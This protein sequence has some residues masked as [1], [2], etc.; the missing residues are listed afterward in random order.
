MGKKLKAKIHVR[1][2]IVDFLKRTAKFLAGS[3]AADENQIRF[4]LEKLEAKWDEFEEAQADIEE[5]DDHEEN[6]EAHREVR[7]NFEEMYFEVRAGLVGKLPH[8]TQTH[9]TQGPSLSVSQSE[10]TNVH[11]YVRLPQINLPEFDGSFDKWLPF[12]DTFKALIDSS[13]DLSGIQKFHYLRASLRGDALKL[14]DSYPMSEANYD[15]AWNGLVA[16]FSNGYLLKKRHLN[17]MFEFPKIRKESAIGIHDVIDC[18][19]RNTKILDQLGERTSSW[20]AM[21]THLMVSKLDDVTQKRWEEHAS[22]EA[23]PSFAVLLEFLKKQTRVLDAVLVDQKVSTAQGQPTLGGIKS[24][25]PKISVNSATER[26]VQNCV[27][28]GEQH[29]IVQCPSFNQLPVDKRLQLS[30]SKRLCS[31]C[32]GWNHLARDCPSKYRCRTCGK[33]HHSL[34]HPG[35]PG[36][37][38]TSTF[39][40]EASTVQGVHIAG[41]T[42]SDDISGSGGTVTSSLA[43]IATNMAIEHPGKHIFLL[44]VLLKI[45]D[46]W[47][48]THLARGLLDSGSQANL[49]SERLCQLLKLPRRAKR[50]EISGIGQTRRNTAHEVSASISS[51]ILDFSLSMDFLVLGEVTADQP[52]SSLPLAKWVLPTGMQLADP[53][54]HVSGP[55]DLVLGSQFYYDFHLL[56]G[57]RIQVRRLDSTLPIFVNTVFGWVAAGESERSSTG[58]TVSCHLATAE[59]LDKAIEKFW[60]IEEM[61][62]KPLRSQEEEDCEQ[63]FQATITRD[64]TG[65][66]VARYPKKI[67]FHEKIGDSISTALRRFSQLERRLNRDANLHRQYSDFLQEYLDLDHMRL[68]GTVKDVQDDERTVCYLPHH[69]VFKESSSTTKVRVVFDGSA[70][71]T[72]G[73]SLNEALLTGPVIQ[74]DLIDLMIRFRK[75]SIALVA[76][77]AKMY[78][79]VR[80]HPDDTP[81]QRILWRFNQDEPIQIFEL[82]TVT[83]GLSPSSFIATRALKQ[84]ANDVGS[85]YDHAA[86]AVTE[87]FYM[88]DF[89]SGEDSVAKAKI[90]RDEVQ[91]LM[92]EGGFE[93]RK[94]SS[95]SPEA[96]CD[97]PPDALEGQPT[98]HFD[99]EQKVKT[100]GVAW[101]TRSDCLSIDILSI[102]V[103][104][105]WTKRKIFSAIAQLYD[106]LGLVSPVVAWAKIKMQQLWLVP[107]DWDDLVPD[108]SVEKWLEFCMQLPLLQDFKVPRCILIQSSTTIQFHT[109]SDASEVGYGA[110]IYARSINDEGEIKVQLVAAKSRVAPIKRL[111]LPR[112]ELCAALLGAKLYVKV[113]TAL[114][115]EGTPCWFWSDSMVTLHWIQAPPNTWQTFVGNRTS[116]IQLLTHGHKWAHVKGTDNPA[117]HVS[118][119]MLPGDFVNNSLWVHGPPWLEGAETDWPK[120]SNLLPLAEDVLERRKT[121]LLVQSTMEQNPLFERYSSYWRL[122]RITAYLRRFINRCRSKNPLREPFLTTVELQEAKETLV[123]VVQQ[124]TFSEE[125]KQLKQK[126]PLPKKFPLKNGRPIIDEKGILRLGGRL[127]YSNE[128]YQTPHSPS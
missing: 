61:M 53:E 84:L 80:I 21:L 119:G 46:N 26:K 79:Q 10:S 66:Y 23:E 102:N 4:R 8:N 51:R 118:R 88:D 42:T 100:L 30:N 85:K 69:P 78:R 15:V 83:Y 112:L 76:D 45:K 38:S 99:G 9:S 98:V 91:S 31:N 35:F 65:R 17:A 39:D 32:L 123:K 16:R 93:L 77:V 111:S 7:E 11:A 104:Q 71:T 92:A 96:L 87:D 126:G 116:E 18:F 120:Q 95:N 73:C 110:C 40:S 14:V 108:E 62:D 29:S 5:T 101:E 34:L 107:I 127:N 72:T 37:G 103:E 94:W 27:S 58:A 121:V 68:V 124:E 105:Q 41:T 115:M 56:D 81:L 113:S 36:S 82:Q 59:P 19:E 63:H 67:G 122:V 128:N 60:T 97:L 125:V 114:K 24:R 48:R 43:S 64:C 54:F 57:G 6:M 49:M 109:F 47:G 52:S 90:L 3:Q 1:D 106:P 20:G 44:T 22:D 2:N 89:L 13:P 55:I 33:K 74:D 25:P 75:H 28:C 12:H 117:D 86:T 70:K 50:V